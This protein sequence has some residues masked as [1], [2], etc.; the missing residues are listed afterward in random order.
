MSFSAAKR[1]ATSAS[2]ATKAMPGKRTLANS[3]TA[4]HLPPRGALAFWAAALSREGHGTRADAGTAGDR[5]LLDSMSDTLATLPSLALGCMPCFA[6]NGLEEMMAKLLDRS[7]CP[8]LRHH[9]ETAK[10][11]II[12]RR[13]LDEAM[14]TQRQA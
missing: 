7:S 4:F 1:F 11:G 13:N 3:P 2:T 14:V 5:H 10:A 8:M 6:C 12:G 9:R